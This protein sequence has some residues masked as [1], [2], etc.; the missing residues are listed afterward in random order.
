MSSRYQNGALVLERSRTAD[1][2][3]L[4]KPEL[5]FLSV[6]TA[7]GGA[8]LGTV[9]IASGTMLFLHVMVG[10]LL[11]GGGAGALNQY[12]ERSFDALMKRTENRPVPSGRVSAG[13]ARAFGVL[14]T[15]MGL[16]YLLATTNVLTAALGLLTAVSYLFVYTPLKRKTWWST[17]IGGIPGALPPVMGWAAVRGSLGPESLVLFLILFF[18][19]MP[20][21]FSLAWMYRKDYERAGFPLLTVIDPDGTRTSIQIVSHMVAL[22]GAAAVLAP[23]AGLGYWYLAGSLLL[24]ILFLISGVHLARSRSNTSARA[25]FFASLAYL[26]FLLAFVVLDGILRP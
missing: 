25:V 3:S 19:Q 24:S 9:D 6:L 14:L 21:F 17:I 10:T 12:I 4:T 18:W 7:L 5:T 1:F 22:T 15:V 11:V 2:I 20:H 23:V 8:Y 26:P 13:E 16:L